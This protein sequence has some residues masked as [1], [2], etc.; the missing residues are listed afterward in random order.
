MGLGAHGRRVVSFFRLVGVLASVT[1]LGKCASDASTWVLLPMCYLQ[2]GAAGEAGVVRGPR[3]A[4]Q[5][6][7]GLV[8]VRPQMQYHG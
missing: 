6:P 3:K 4:P 1:Q 2:R 5:D 7:A 8:T